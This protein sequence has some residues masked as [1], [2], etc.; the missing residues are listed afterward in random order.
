VA[1]LKIEIDGQNAM[2]PIFRRRRDETLSVGE[3]GLR[4]L[5]FAVIRVVVLGMRAVVVPSV[6]LS[7]R[8]IER[9]V[10]GANVE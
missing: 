5:P 2:R 8:I 7:E 9:S 10:D 3:S 4:R 1:A 6:D